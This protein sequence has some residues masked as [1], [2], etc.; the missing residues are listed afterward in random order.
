MFKASFKRHFLF[1]RG[2]F[3]QDKCS[4][5]SLSFGSKDITLFLSTHH[6]LKNLQNLLGKN[7]FFGYCF[8]NMKVEVE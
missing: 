6:R 1:K 5:F 8:G 3:K 2:S 7:E 4:E